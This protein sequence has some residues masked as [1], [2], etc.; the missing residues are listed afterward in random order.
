MKNA[1]YNVIVHENNYKP[2]I[3][4]KIKIIETHATGTESLDFIVAV[5]YRKQARHTVTFKVHPM[6]LEKFF[7]QK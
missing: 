6:R 2:I 3:L 1:N 7:A 5:L 4:R